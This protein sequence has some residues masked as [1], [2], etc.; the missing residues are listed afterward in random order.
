M[1]NHYHLLVYLKTDRFSKLM[2]AFTLSYAKAISKRYQRM[3]SLFQGRFQAISVDRE[4][5][6]LHLSRYINL[7][8]ERLPFRNGI[9]NFFFK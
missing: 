2:Q 3:G 7:N 9:D 1:P 6:L 8:P 5:Y 4:E